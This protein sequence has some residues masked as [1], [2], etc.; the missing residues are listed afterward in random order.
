MKS[1]KQRVTELQKREFCLF[2]FSLFEET[3][4]R[5]DAFVFRR[6]IA[7]PCHLGQSLARAVEERYSG[8]LTD[9]FVR[10]GVLPGDTALSGGS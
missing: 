7:K 1:C 3:E 10:V 5:K 6:R 2:F 4:Q 9:M 8:T